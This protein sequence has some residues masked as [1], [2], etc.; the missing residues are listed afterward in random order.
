MTVTELHW[1]KVNNARWETEEGIATRRSPGRGPGWE[2][3][4]MITYGGAYLLKMRSAK[5]KM[6]FDTLQ[7]AKDYAESI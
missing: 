2:P 5:Q 1:V 4:F 7:E 6:W 3:D